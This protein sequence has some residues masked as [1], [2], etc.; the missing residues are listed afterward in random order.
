MGKFRSNEPEYAWKVSLYVQL[1]AVSLQAYAYEASSAKLRQRGHMT[2]SRDQAQPW[3]QP[4]T[5]SISQK[6]NNFSIKL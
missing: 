2:E 5:S 3:V 4:I 6:A 1:V